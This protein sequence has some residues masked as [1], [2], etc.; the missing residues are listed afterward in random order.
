VPEG[1][2]RVKLFRLLMAVGFGFVKTVVL[3]M[4]LPLSFL[5]FVPIVFR[6]GQW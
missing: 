3:M 5:I 4:K 2:G 6:F 1:I